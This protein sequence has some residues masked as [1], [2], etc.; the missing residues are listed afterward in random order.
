MSER[1]WKPKRDTSTYLAELLKIVKNIK[2]KLKCEVYFYSDLLFL[3]SNSRRVICRP[4]F[5]LTFT[6]MTLS[7]APWS[8]RGHSTIS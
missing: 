3:F 2:W 4:F 7:R 5:V 6:L 1:K 8:Y